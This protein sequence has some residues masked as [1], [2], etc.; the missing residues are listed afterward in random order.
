MYCEITV[1]NTL[2]SAI[3]IV[4]CC[5]TVPLLEPGK[6]M[7][8]D[9]C[10]MERNNKKIVFGFDQKIVFYCVPLTNWEFRTVLP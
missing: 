2:I 8:T 3:L 1:A 10:C 9:W 4:L 7:A 5:P 6:H